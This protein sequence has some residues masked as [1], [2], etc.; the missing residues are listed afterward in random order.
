MY[1]ILK[2]L[3]VEFDHINL[4]NIK[5]YSNYEVYPSDNLNINF[6]QKHS[7]Q[8]YQMFGHFQT[9]HYHKELPEPCVGVQNFVNALS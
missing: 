4:T 5:L 3:Q 8:L 1:T 6:A 2:M 9:S 7:A